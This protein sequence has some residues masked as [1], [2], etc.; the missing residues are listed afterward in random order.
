MY[1]VHGLGI[2]SV[3]CAQRAREGKREGERRKLQER[4]IG[5]RF[6]GLGFRV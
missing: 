5:F 4:E 2:R 6:Q 1:S 3:L